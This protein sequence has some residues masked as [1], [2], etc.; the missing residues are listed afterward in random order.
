MLDSSVMNPTL[1][2]WYTPLKNRYNTKTFTSLSFVVSLSGID[3]LIGGVD[4]LVRRAS[5]GN[6]VESGG[7]S[8]LS[9]TESLHRASLPST[10]KER[11][12]FQHLL[13]GTCTVF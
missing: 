7:T 6:N 3:A 8:V 2:F 1:F 10:E 13:S 5:Y 11:G 12:E 9:E 4:M